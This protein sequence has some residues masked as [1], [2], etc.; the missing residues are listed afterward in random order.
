M[1]P[2]SCRRF[3][4]DG[5]KFDWLVKAIIAAFSV[6]IFC[7]VYMQSDDLT[8]ALSRLII[9]TDDKFNVENP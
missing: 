2:W 9:I 5:I 3:V 1:A 7:E 8:W 6:Y 4:H